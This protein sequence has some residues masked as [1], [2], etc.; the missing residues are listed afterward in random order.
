MGKFNKNKINIF[1][2]INGLQSGG[3]EKQL[4]YISNY[5]SESYNIFIFTTNSKKTNYKFN[6]RIKIY[7]L[8]YL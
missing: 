8:R 7:K 2:C 6:S 4:N 5:L 1:F 3:A